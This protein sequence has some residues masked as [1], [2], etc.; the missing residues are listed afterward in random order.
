M[1]GKV[2][3]VAVKGSRSKNQYW[4]NEFESN[5]CK[6]TGGGKTW[7]VSAVKSSNERKKNVT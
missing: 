4:I 2:E 3:S 1:G 5:T 7:R 6:V